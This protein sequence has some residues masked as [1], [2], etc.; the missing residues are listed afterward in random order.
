M[1]EC[2]TKLVWDWLSEKEETERS[3]VTDRPVSVSFSFAE[4][5][6]VQGIVNSEQ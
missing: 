4:K 1:S 5:V 2:Q 3:E 6:N